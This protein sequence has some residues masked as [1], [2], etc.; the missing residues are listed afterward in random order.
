MKYN[1]SIL[2]SILQSLNKK[3]EGVSQNSELAGNIQK[4]QAK[5]IYMQSKQIPVVKPAKIISIFK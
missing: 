1:Y 2:Y 3:K 4:K 5:V